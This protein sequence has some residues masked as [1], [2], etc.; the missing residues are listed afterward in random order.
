MNRVTIILFKKEWL[1]LNYV[2]FV[3]HSPP[4]LSII[5]LDSRSNAP[6]HDFVFPRSKFLHFFFFFR[7]FIATTPHQTHIQTSLNRRSL[8]GRRVALHSLVLQYLLIWGNRETFQIVWS[9]RM[10][11]SKAVSII[12]TKFEYQILND[13]CL[14][15]FSTKSFTIWNIFS[16]DNRLKCFAITS[17][18]LPV[19]ILG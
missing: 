15:L 5:R 6:F 7:R 8:E 19:V 14:N 12:L 4:R 16:Q 17:E 11:R 18:F 3:R 9:S 2:M 10:D 13:D 1:W